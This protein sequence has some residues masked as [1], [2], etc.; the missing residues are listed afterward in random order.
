MIKPKTKGGMRI[1]DGKR[2]D[3]TNVKPSLST[4]KITTKTPVKVAYK[5]PDA[6]PI[7]I[8]VPAGNTTITVKSKP[9]KEEETMD[10]K[11]LDRRSFSSRKKK[12]YKR[13]KDDE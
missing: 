8:S 4:V 6:D 5:L 13:S 9:E 7:Q 11:P 3:R 12:K 10:I 2:P 1:I